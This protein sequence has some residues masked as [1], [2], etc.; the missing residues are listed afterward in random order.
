M[1]ELHSSHFGTNRMKKIALSYF[2]WPTID[3]DISNITVS[4][5]ICLENRDNPEKALLSTWPC[6]ESVW[7]SCMQVMVR[8][9]RNKA[10][11]MDLCGSKA[12]IKVQGRLVKR[13][14][15][16]MLKCAVTV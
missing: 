5:L 9:Y 7:E 4:C 1:N 8:D 12:V 11:K 13:H 15:N 2:W 6:S 10:K 3:K 16:Q 14:V